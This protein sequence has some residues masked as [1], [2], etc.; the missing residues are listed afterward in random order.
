MPN[1]ITNYIV[2]KGDQKKIDELLE[3]VS[4][5]KTPTAEENRF[6]FNGLVPMPQELG[7]TKSP[8]EIVATQEEADSTNSKHT[9]SEW[10]AQK[11]QVISQAEH[12][13]RLNEYGADN[14]Y[15]WSLNHWGTKWNAYEAFYMG[16]DENE[17]ALVF[18]TAWSFPEPIFKAIE[19]QYGLEVHCKWIDEGGWDG[20]YGDPEESF[21]IHINVEY[22][23]A[24]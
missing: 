21:Y 23:G 3:K 19:E 6:D 22:E 17:V 18:Q 12:D 4:F 9:P 5:K 16:E 2:I 14:W 15:D 10:N 24:N 13:R 20:E 11:Y 7:E 1:H 8:V